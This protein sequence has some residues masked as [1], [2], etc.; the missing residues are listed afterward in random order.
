MQNIILFFFFLSCFYFL[1]LRD[2]HT[3]AKKYPCSFLISPVSCWFK[4]SCTFTY[5]AALAWPAWKYSFLSC[6][7]LD[8][9]LLNN[10]IKGSLLCNT[11][12]WSHLPGAQQQNS[13]TGVMQQDKVLTDMNGNSMLK[14]EGQQRVPLLMLLQ[15]FRTVVFTLKDFTSSSNVPNAILKK[16]FLC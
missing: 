5:P 10:Q 9:I 2:D 1:K 3:Y 11:E 6:N 12:Y 16:C 15:L 7:I 4:C 8:H 13:S 14:S